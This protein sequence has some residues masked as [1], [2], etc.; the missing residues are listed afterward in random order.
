MTPLPTTP[1]T[2][3]IETEHLTRRFGALIAVND[4]TLRVQRGEV[5]GFLGPNGSGKTTTIRLLCAVLEPTAGTA[6]VLG[7]DVARQADEIKQR[8]GYMS[9]RFALYTDLTTRENL[10]FYAGV[11]GLSGPLRRQRVDEF[12]QRAALTEV[13]T[14]VTGSLSGGLRQRLAFGCAALH[15][16]AI[17]FL[18]EATSG[19]DPLSRRGFWDAIHSLAAEGITVFVTTHYL[20]EAEYCHRLGLM[21]EGRLVAEGT[22]TSLKAGLQDT[23]IE[24]DCADPVAALE[25]AERL[26]SVQEAS[27]YGHQLHVLLDGGEGSDDPVPVTAALTDAGI[28]V[29]SAGRILPTLEDVFV[30]TVRQHSPPPPP[31][32]G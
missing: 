26:P 32:G 24:V 1:T 19:A 16:P 28:A 12:I 7:Y 30:A 25:V 13:A 31:A 11:Y 5:F 21:R 9:Q 8:I 29:R 17:L 4:V 20:D 6:R 14:T 2:P 23:L 18:D 15:R 10:E 3:A 27:L 22:P